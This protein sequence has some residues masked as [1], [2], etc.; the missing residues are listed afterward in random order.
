VAIEGPYDVTHDAEF[1][2]KAIELLSGRVRNWIADV[3][4]G[5]DRDE[6]LQSQLQFALRDQTDMEQT[7]DTF[8]A[9]CRRVLRPTE[10]D[11]PTPR[12][13]LRRR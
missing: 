13:F 5:R 1:A 2:A 6:L 4:G 3:A 10:R 9:G 11:W 8:T 12:G 7:L